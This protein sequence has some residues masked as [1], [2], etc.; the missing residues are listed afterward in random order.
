VGAVVVLIVV[1]AGMVSTTYVQFLKGGLLVIFSSIL[2]L[3]ILNRGFLVGGGEGDTQSILQPQ[4][5]VE[6]AD[7]RVLVNGLPQGTGAGEGDLRPV[8]HISRLPDDR[9]ATGPLGP[10]EFLRVLQ[11]SDVVLWS[12]KKE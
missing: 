1:T 3:L 11:N 4:T 8:G 9:A 12:S 10:L 2:T 6:T 7:G 5:L